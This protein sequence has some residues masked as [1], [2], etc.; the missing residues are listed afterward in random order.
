[1]VAAKAA[2]TAAEA[3]MTTPKAAATTMLGISR[4]GAD[5]QNTQNSDETQQGS[6]HGTLSS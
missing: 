1:M 4:G 5:S 3:A 2:V 6:T